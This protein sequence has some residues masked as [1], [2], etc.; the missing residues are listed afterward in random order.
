MS[1]NFLVEKRESFEIRLAQFWLSCYL[2]NQWVINQVNLRVG[3]PEECRNTSPSHTE[4]TGEVQ[5]FYSG[6]YGTARR[7]TEQ[8]GVKTEQPGGLQNK[9]SETM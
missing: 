2:C 3:S 9:G 4:K 1:V 8:L 6:H 7:S 5:N